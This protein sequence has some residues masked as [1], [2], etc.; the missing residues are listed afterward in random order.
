MKQ[1]LADILHIIAGIG[2][3]LSGWVASVFILA[4]SLCFISYEILLYLKRKDR[5]HRA[6]KYFL[7]GLVGTA[8]FFALDTIITAIKALFYS[9]S[10]Y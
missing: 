2:V 1:L 4:G 9:P 5:P 7:V 10:Y 8:L 6:I 3:A